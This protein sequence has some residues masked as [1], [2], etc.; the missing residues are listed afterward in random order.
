MNN[1]LTRRQ[2]LI[3]GSGVLGGV[4]C[5]GCK[6]ELP[7]TYGTILQLGDA[8]T[9]AAHRAI[10]PEQALVK[11]FDRS[12]ISPFPAINTTDPEDETYQRL[13][14][15]GFVDWRLLVDGL[16]K[17][18]KAYSVADLMNFPSRTQIT[19]HQCE[20][21]WTAIGEWTGVQLSRILTSA[22]ISPNARYVVS[23]A[24]D[25]HWD[26]LDMFDA[27]HPQTL[28]A[29]GMN[30]NVLP[31]PHGAPVRLRVE[32]QLGYKSVKYVNR[33]TVTDNL[34]NI[35]DGTGSGMTAYGGSW[36][37]GI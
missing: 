37:A 21:G 3:A 7:P 19:Q 27:L 20:Q 32:R 28:L 14:T 11:E 2:M 24:A 18:P 36:Y 33:L 8:L 15:T 26:S 31:V 23:Y 17:Q 4:F 10:L 5:T 25:G 9:Y 1:K 34:A 29:Y 22:G 12:Q 35:K 13:K 6:L 16:V 30:G